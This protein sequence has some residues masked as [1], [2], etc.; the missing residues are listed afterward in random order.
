MTKVVILGTHAGTI[1]MYSLA[2]GDIVKR[3]E[4]VHTLPIVD[5]I[6]NKAGTKGYSISEDNY[7]V[8]WDIEEGHEIAKWKS[9]AK[10]IRRLKLSH[11]ETKLATAGHTISLWDLAERKV[12]K[13]YTGHASSVLNIVFSQHDDIL[14]SIAED[15]R[16]INV[17]DAQ[18]TNTNT[19]NIATLVLEDNVTHINFSSIQ[20]SVLAVSEDGT[21]GIWEHASINNNNNRQTNGGP[22]RRKLMRGAMTR[23]AD[24]VISVI[25][26]QDEVTKIPII[27]A[28]FVS[29]NDGRSVMIARGSSI[30]PIFEV[31]RYINEETGTILDNIV[32]SRQLI[33]NYLMDE[34]SMANENLKKTNKSYNEHHVKVMGNTDFTPK[35]PSMAVEHID[36]DINPEELTL[37]Q[38]LEA[39]EMEGDEENNEEDDEE[40]EKEQTS[41]SKKS[42]KKRNNNNKKSVKM[43][44]AQSLK[45]VLVQALHS[46]DT[47]LLEGCL[48]HRNQELIE[49]TIRRLPTSYVI[50]LL[51][52][53]IDLFQEN[54]AR[55]QS[56][57]NWIKP[58]LRIHTAY[59]MTVPDLVGKL[60]NFY[61]AMDTHT[62]A[63]PKL[64]SLEGRL[65]VINAQID[66][67]SHTL[68]TLIQH[69]IKDEKPKHVY[70]EQVSDDEAEK[71]DDMVD[72]VLLEDED[73]DMNDDDSEEDS[74][75]DED[76]F[77]ADETISDSD[78]E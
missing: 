70:V 37:E 9:D 22:P 13:K 40:V 39:I 45:T 59:L 56:I 68:G 6:L 12:V 65:K 35:N 2:H 23:P 11:N 32:L 36:D 50:P 3:L 58:T 75:S 47:V 21:C 27:S 51:L 7:I 38:R 18:T 34:S 4:G 63:L 24:T 48:Q 46:N 55:T 49:T 42:T 66:V 72:E 57:M 5:F 28:R 53:L 74:D 1:I 16:Y 17:W 15:D 61:Q 54:P 64:L 14:V 69:S 73:M 31:V 77:E 20:P 71:L 10:N 26:S 25:A 41:D 52:Q 60:S 33:T 30:K 76:G 62:R 44:A 19:N 78:E 29:D 43:P 8:E 67:R